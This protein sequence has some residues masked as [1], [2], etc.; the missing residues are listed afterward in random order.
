MVGGALDQKAIAM[1]RYKNYG[2]LISLDAEIDSKLKELQIRREMEFVLGEKPL[3]EWDDFVE[4]WKKAGGQTLMDQA[5]EQL[6]VAS[7]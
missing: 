1:A 2:M 4:E 5:A 7:Q 6:G 3:S